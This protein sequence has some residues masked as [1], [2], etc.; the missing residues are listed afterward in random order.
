MVREEAAKRAEALVSS[1]LRLS[2]RQPLS[3]ARIREREAEV[4]PHICRALGE[5][6]PSKGRFGVTGRIRKRALPLGRR[7]TVPLLQRNRFESSASWC[8]ITG[9]LGVLLPCFL[10]PEPAATFSARRSF[11]GGRG[12][13][14]SS[15]LCA[16]CPP[17]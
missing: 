13:S 7:E 17:G 5:G 15:S 4:S 8:G 6:P 10:P 1:Q 2:T 14:G 9:V 12:D 16:F 3:P 11:P